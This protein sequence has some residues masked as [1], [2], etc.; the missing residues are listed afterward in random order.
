MFF[1]F[2]RKERTKEKRGPTQFLRQKNKKCKVLKK[3][4]KKFFISLERKTEYFFI[5]KK[6]IYFLVV[7]VGAVETVERENLG[8]YFGKSYAR[9]GCG[10]EEEEGPKKFIT[11]MR[12]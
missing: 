2:P 7:I 3:K 9:W 11:I 4:K 12:L 1:L 8:E 6:I 5:R 10:Q